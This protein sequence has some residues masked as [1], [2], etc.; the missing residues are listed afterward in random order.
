[1]RASSEAALAAAKERW[2][3]LLV[4]KASGEI[5]FAGE[6][7]AVADALGSSAAV[8]R[9]LTD[10]ARNGEDRTRLASD[11]FAGKVS[12]EVLDLLK[13]LVR[14]HWAGDGDL[15]ACL[16]EIGV[17][18]VLA[19]AQRAG[20][21]TDVEDELYR[22]MR[23]L[24]DER[25][26]RMAISDS[27]RS[28]ADR[29][30]LVRRVFSTGAPE[31]VELVVH[32][33]RRIGDATLAQSL[34]RFGALAAERSRHLVATVI[35]ALPPTPEQEARLVSILERRYGKDVALHVSLDPSIL[36][37]LRIAIGND[38][39]DGT[40]ATRLAAVHEEITK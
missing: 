7:F 34:A 21:L 37:G 36:G 2:N 29:E 11:I 15:L 5:G 19:G 24:R 3:A 26:L 4:E 39:I 25:E 9:S 6:I 12:G 38:V 10:P 40:L 18:T 28:F 1:M 8:C 27:H 23:T 30:A 14:E 16:D 13:G 17:D 31:T 22:T 33:A 20:R 32:A 35:A